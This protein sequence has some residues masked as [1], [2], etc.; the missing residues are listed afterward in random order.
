MPDP[1][2]PAHH[3]DISRAPSAAKRRAPSADTVELAD[4]S[5]L[6]RETIAVLWPHKFREYRGFAHAA[7]A[8]LGGAVKAKTVHRWLYA[9][10]QRM[11]ASAARALA[12]LLAAT[13][14]RC[15]SLS[16][17]WTRWAEA[18]EARYAAI[19]QRTAARLL[20]NHHPSL[21]PAAGHPHAPPAPP[22][23]PRTSP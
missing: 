4:F 5:I 21:R 19:S 3:S 7:V 15:I 23:P 14:Q 22:A 20:V 18:E 13:A 9:G 10:S 6:L 11:P 1:I 2:I 12:S 8:A 17:A 16:L